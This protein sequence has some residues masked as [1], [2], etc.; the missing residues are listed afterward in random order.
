MLQKLHQ[1]L[2]VHFTWTFIPLKKVN[3]QHTAEALPGYVASSVSHK[4]GLQSRSGAS[5][6]HYAFN[7]T[8]SGVVFA[9]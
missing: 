8:T 6:I 9:F 2:D 1:A 3:T 4:P 5:G 7:Q